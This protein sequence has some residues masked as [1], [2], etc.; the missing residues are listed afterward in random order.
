MQTSRL[1]TWDLK[2]F[3]Q[4]Q[5]NP[6]NRRIKLE[7]EKGRAFITIVHGIEENSRIP[8]DPEVFPCIKGPKIKN[9]WSSDAL[10]E[11]NEKVL[12]VHKKN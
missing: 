11:A 9:F 1:G 3:P 5:D 4:Q 12:K 10:Q 6:S 2:T 7:L 8:A